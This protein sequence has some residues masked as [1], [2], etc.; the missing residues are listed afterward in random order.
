MQRSN[1]SSENETTSCRWAPLWVG[2]GLVALLFTGACA[3]GGGETNQV[4]FAVSDTPVGDLTSV[5]ITIE[6]ITVNRPGDDIVIERAR[7]PSLGPSSPAPR[8]GDLE[9]SRL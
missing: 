5:T 8:N 7:A 4:S 6:R 3:D 1:Q 9:D 2:L